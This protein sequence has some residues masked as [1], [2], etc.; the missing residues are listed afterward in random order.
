[1]LVVRV[2]VVL[3]H[4]GVGLIVPVQAEAVIKPG[5]QGNAADV[6]AV[7]VTLAK[8]GDIGSAVGNLPKAVG[9][10]PKS[11]IGIAPGIEIGQVTGAAPPT[12]NQA[13]RR[14][15]RIG[16]TLQHGVRYLMNAVDP[17]AVVDTSAR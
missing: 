6:V 4:E 5:I 11:I 7:G 3:E 10:R 8:K 15:G 9:R 14:G 17:D 12:V 1:M 16:R 13:V 2:G